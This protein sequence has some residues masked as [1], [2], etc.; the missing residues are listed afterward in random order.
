MH[1]SRFPGAAEAVFESFGPQAVVTHLHEV[2]G[3]ADH[4]LPGRGNGQVPWD[5][6]ADCLQGADNSAVAALEIWVGRNG[7]ST[8]AWLPELNE[9]VEFFRSCGLLKSY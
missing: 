9:A 5:R 6:L 4:N 1:A 3:G 7:R 2:Y 8:S